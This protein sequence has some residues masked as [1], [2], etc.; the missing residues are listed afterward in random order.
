[1]KYV[2]FGG[3]QYAPVHTRKGKLNFRAAVA[4]GRRGFDEFRLS[5]Y[6]LCI[7]KGAGSRGGKTDDLHAD[8]LLDREIVPN[9][10]SEEEQRRKL[11]VMLLLWAT[12]LENDYELRL[13]IATK[14]TPKYSKKGR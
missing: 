2:V 13:P 1:M 5:V 9:W 7:S 14:K 11:E 8:V 3:K 4:Y 6:C 12:R 10:T